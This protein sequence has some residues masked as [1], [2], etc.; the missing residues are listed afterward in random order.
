MPASDYTDIESLSEQLM[1]VSNELTKRTKLVAS[2]RQIREYDGDRRKRALSL[3][4]RDVMNAAPD[5]SAT[6]AEHKARAC[7]G[8]G[9]SMN[10]LRDEL[11]QAETVVAEWEAL[12][13]RFESLRSLLSIQKQIVNNL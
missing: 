1:E 7:D 5:T 8:Y 9:D 4:V 10:K 6:A 12:K 11:R 13:I 2:A 3:S